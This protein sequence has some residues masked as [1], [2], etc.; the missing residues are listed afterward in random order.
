MSEH[1]LC[2]YKMIKTENPDYVRDNTSH[3]LIN[4]NAIAYKQ[5]VQSRQSQKKVVDIENEVY[6]LKKDVSD[7]KDML[8][9]LIKQNNKEN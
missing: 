5:Y 3:A 4:T 1:W 7:I 8:M 9:I 2:Q 6:N